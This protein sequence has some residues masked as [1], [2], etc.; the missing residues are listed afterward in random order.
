LKYAVAVLSVGLASFARLQLEPLLGSSCLHATFYLAVLGSAAF[1]GWKPG[2]LAMGLTELSVAWL[3]TTPNH[4]VSFGLSRGVGTLTF[5]IVGGSAIAFNEAQRLA[6]RRTEAVVARL[7]QEVADRRLAEAER[8]QLLLE[9]EA[10]KILLNSVL[11]QMPVGVIIAQAPSGKVLFGND[12]AGRILR[13]SLFA[14]LK[15]TER[16]QEWRG[17]HTDGRPYQPEEWPLARAINHSEI[18]KDEDIQMLL[19]DGARIRVTVSAAPIADA[20]GRIAAGIMTLHDLTARTAAELAV[21]ES[22]ERYRSLFENNLDPVF[23]LDLQGRFVTVNPAGLKLSGYSLAELKGLP[24]TAVCAPGRAEEALHHFACA[25]SGEPEPLETVLVTKDGRRVDLFIAGG[26]VIVKGDA[27]GVFAIATDITEQKRTQARLAAFSRLGR[28]LSSV[29][30][31]VEAGRII[32]SLAENLFG[33][34]A[35]SLILCAP[36]GDGIHHVL[37]F[38][39]IDG[40]KRELEEQPQH[41]TM[42]AMM[43]RVLQT[44][45]ELILKEHPASHLP[46]CVPFGDMARPSASLMFVPIRDKGSSI[47]VLSVQSYR[48]RAY[49]ENDLKVLQSLADY[50]GGALERIRAES[51]LALSNERLSLI[52]KVTNAVVGVIPLAEEVRHLAETVRLA[53]RVDLCV[54]RVLDGDAL[55]LLGSAGVPEENMPL[56]LPADASIPA[57]LISRRQPVYVPDVLQHAGAQALYATLP[58]L[59][60]IVSYAGAPLLAQNQTIGIISICTETEVR[61]FTQTDL[62]QLQII[63]NHLAVMI[64]NDRLYK[65]VSRQK[66]QLEQQ[67]A[68]RLLAEQ[69]V[70]NLNAGLERRV[71][72]RTEELVAA[73]QELEAFCYSVSHDLRAPLR[74]IAGFTQ[75]LAED[76]RDQLQP[77]G[78]DS[79]DRVI[80]STREM[81]Q[82]IDDLLHLSRITRSDMARRTVDLSRV[83]QD[84]AAELQRREPVRIVE[85]LLTPELAVQGDGRLL[86]IALENLLSNAW[87]FTGKRARARIEFGIEPRPAGSAFYVRDNGAGFDKAYAGK[88]FGAFQRLHTMSE[89]PGHGIGLA[90]V[91]RIIHR[92]GGRVWAVAEVDQGATFYFTLPASAGAAIPQNAGGSQ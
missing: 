58:K 51:A 27:V 52:A 23:T 62:E 38:D 45:P 7:E 67:V 12:E 55:V 77:D 17:F 3:V 56:Q 25:L 78:K 86:R 43:L 20:E 16:N 70:Q 84:I 63:A 80:E 2:L 37:R 26:P 39:T 46:D 50:C 54:I 83:A 44:G 81:D 57:E 61:N 91:Q 1:G 71:Q 22:E 88:L 73:N 60:P 64:A 11:Q 6:R 76:C 21:A 31:P 5:F 15:S 34:D 47:G 9:L 30:T 72:E 74:S 18:V 69:Q 85:F 90:T 10:E 28:S 87:K 14:G 42:S 32:G 36:E 33:W 48:P 79:L 59:H 29:R 49:D 40:Q 35:C 41:S 75:A 92:H 8:Y 24:F 68:D 19:P 13:R 4:L 65:E 66:Q 82:L 89:F 53:Y